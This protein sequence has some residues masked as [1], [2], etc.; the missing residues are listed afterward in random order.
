MKNTK[1]VSSL[2]YILSFLISCN[3][4]AK[5]EFLI[6]GELSGNAAK[7]V[8]LYEILPDEIIVIDSASIINGKFKFKVQQSQTSFYKISFNQEVKIDFMAKASD[9]LSVSGDFT[10]G[11][12]SF[13]I[14]GSEENKVFQEMN[15]RLREC[16]KI[17]DSLSKI[18]TNSVYEPDYE[19]IKNNIDT[20]YYHMFNN[21]KEWLRKTIIANK[22]S[23]LSIKAFYET[24]GNKRFFDNHQ[25]FDLMTIIYT[26]LN[27][28]CK[29]NVHVIQF[30]S[31]FEKIKEEIEAD[32]KIKAALKPGKPVPQMSFFTNEKGVV[33]TTDFKGENLI[34]YF[35]GF[36]S[37]PS[38]D[39]FSK[40]N[41]FV[42]KNKVE[43]MSISLNPNAEDALAFSQQKMPYAIC[44]NEEKMFE[45]QAARIFDVKSVPYCFLINA[46]G[47]IV[48]HSNSLDTISS[49]YKEM[50]K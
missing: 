15:K 9:M 45:S 5:N 29:E 42:K 40:M 39:E 43:V 37:K 46:E 31:K 27:A 23:L 17:T 47:N 14:A 33:S 16:Y 24:L 10:K 38:I 30:N 6:N 28:S 32:K 11:I 49:Y 8:Y 34:I 36:M 7:K 35:W 44:V 22:N 1:V 48:F 26:E 12:E 21:H 2:I 41:A 25:D 19:M 13:V 3:N 4:T 50:Q 18:L 20:A